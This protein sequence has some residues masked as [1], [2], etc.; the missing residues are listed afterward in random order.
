MFLDSNRSTI[1][2]STKFDIMAQICQAL[3]FMHAKFVGCFFRMQ[4]FLV[5]RNFKV[6]LRNLAYSYAVNQ[7]TG[8]KDARHTNVQDINTGVKLDV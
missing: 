7:K 3:Q 1:S 4:D 8:W 6:K 5:D 2:L